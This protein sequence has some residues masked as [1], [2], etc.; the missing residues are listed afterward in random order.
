MV[1]AAQ[2]RMDLSSIIELAII[3]GLAAL[4]AVLLWLA[5]R[6]RHEGA[7]PLIAASYVWLRPGWYQVDMSVTNRATYALGGVS[8]RRLRPRAARLMAPITSVS[9]KDG[10]F[11]IWSDPVTDRP[12]KTIPLDFVVGAREAPK[13]VASLAFEAH[14]TAWLFV[15]GN[16]PPA[17]VE[18]ELSLRDGEGKLY[19]YRTMV[20]PKP[21]R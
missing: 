6:R 4:A 1:H 16:K 10:D 18:L 13:G 2:W 12:A 15:P 8:L 17:E 11:Q 21:S 19:R 7:A 9:T 3:A 5:L 14:P 20:A